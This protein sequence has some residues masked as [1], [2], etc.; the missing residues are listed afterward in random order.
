MTTKRAA[1]YAVKWWDTRLMQWHV[2]KHLIESEMHQL[3]GELAQME[4]GGHISQ[5]SSWITGNAPDS[6]LR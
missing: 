5:V 3:K 4:A 6:S 1:L 2:R